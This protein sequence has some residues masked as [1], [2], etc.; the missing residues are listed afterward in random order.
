[1]FLQSQRLDGREDGRRIGF[2][3]GFIRVHVQLDLIA[4]RIPQ[5]QTLTH[6]VVAHPV[7]GD[8]GGFQLPLRRP[9]LIEAVADFDADMVEASTSPRRRP[10][11]GP[12]ASPT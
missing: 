11:G 8:A 3:Q 4:V 9:Q 2:P 1:M 10:D 7:D 5:V 6:R 12:G